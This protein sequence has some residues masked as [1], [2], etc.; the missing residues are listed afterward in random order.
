MQSEDVAS[1]LLGRLSNRAANENPDA[2]FKKASVNLFAWIVSQEKYSYLSNFPVF[3]V[4]DKSVLELPSAHNRTPP[5]A[6]V[7]SWS[8]NLQ[9]FADL[10]PP[11]AS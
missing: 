4:D 9:P 8:K 7:C 3:A 11:G 1:Q 2:A 10:F 5:L 6:P